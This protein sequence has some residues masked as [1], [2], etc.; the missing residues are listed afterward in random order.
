MSHRSLMPRVVEQEHLIEPHAGHNKGPAARHPF[1]R[2]DFEVAGL[3][4]PREA[5]LHGLTPISL[6][7]VLPRLRVRR[8]LL[9]SEQPAALLCLEGHEVSPAK[10][11]VTQQEFRDRKVLRGQR[12]LQ[13][14][15]LPHCGGTPPRK[16]GHGGG[17]DQAVQDQA[18]AWFCRKL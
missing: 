13:H 5:Q 11:C 12:L 16:E 1:S 18:I 6:Q 9:G 10:G 15:T 7:V 3:H 8:Q 14:R 17:K 4:N 2:A